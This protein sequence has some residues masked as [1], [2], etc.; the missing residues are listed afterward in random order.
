[1]LTPEETERLLKDAKDSAAWMKAEI[2]RRRSAKSGD[3]TGE[4]KR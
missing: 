3:L 2:K 1:M 4:E